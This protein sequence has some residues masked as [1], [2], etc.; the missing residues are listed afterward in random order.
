MMILQWNQRAA[1]NSVMTSEV[2]FVVRNLIEQPCS[3][4]W[5]VF[6]VPVKQWTNLVTI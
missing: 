2:I 5:D 3:V 1:F 6:I 4:R